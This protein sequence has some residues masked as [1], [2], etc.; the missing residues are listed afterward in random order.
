MINFNEQHQFHCD[1]I[2]DKDHWEEFFISTLIVLYFC[3]I[4]HLEGI[5]TEPYSSQY[6]STKTEQ[7][8]VF[9]NHTLT[10]L[11]SIFQIEWR[12]AEKGDRL[13]VFV[14]DVEVSVKVGKVTTHIWK[15]I[16][17]AEF[18]YETQLC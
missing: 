4:L 8:V 18:T 11:L 13:Q 9:E 15:A 16:R 17:P 10:S 7:S 2:N 3:S 5:N 6:H 14:D 1:A 12:C